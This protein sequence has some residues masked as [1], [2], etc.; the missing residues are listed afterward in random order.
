[1]YAR[2]TISSRQIPT[3]EPMFLSHVALQ[4][5]QKAAEFSSGEMVD[6]ATE[7]WDEQLA[8]TK[9][10]EHAS[11]PVFMSSDLETPFG[12]ASLLACTNNLKKVF[13]PASFN[14]SKMLKSVPR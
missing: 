14:M 11:Q 1:M 2:P 5:G 9:T 4:G 6:Y 10:G 3:N 13:I 7:L 12:F 8:V